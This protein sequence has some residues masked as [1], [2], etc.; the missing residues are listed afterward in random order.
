MVGHDLRDY[1]LLGYGGGGPLH[2]LG[3]AGDHPW[4]AVIT[5]PHAGAFSA[6]GGACMDYAHRRHRSMSAVFTRADAPEARLRNADAVSRAWQELEGE[7]LAELLAEGFRR[8]QIRLRQIAYIR[9]YGQLDDVEVESP[10]PRLAS[11]GDVAA[12]LARFD[13]NFTKMFTLAGRPTEPTWYVTEVGVAAHV[14]T[15]KPVL[16]QKPLEGR[17]PRREAS[18]GRRRVFRKGRW[19]DASIWEMG[20]LRPGNEIEGLAVI[21]APNTTLFVPESWRVRIDER[22][23]Y[24]LERMKEVSL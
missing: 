19:H 5:V 3:Y 21:E 22:E 11:V 9:Y 6:W 23:I 14:D 12:L 4:K 24:W 8:D 7:L 18:K 13:E 16:A 1:V 15:V 17:A 10:V 2:L 20:E